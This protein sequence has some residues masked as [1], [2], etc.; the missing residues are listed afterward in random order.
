M[1]RRFNK[2]KESLRRT[3]DF[4]AGLLI[5]SLAVT[6]VFAAATDMTIDDL[7]MPVLIGS[8]VLLLA[9]LVL[10][11]TRKNAAGP[12]PGVSKEYRKEY[13]EGIGQYRLQLGRGDA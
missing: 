3:S 2:V 6:P 7:R 10:K 9:A 5:G 8:I 13:S 4:I 11:A 12:Q 1:K